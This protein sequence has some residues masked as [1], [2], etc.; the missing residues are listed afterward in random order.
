MKTDVLFEK[1]DNKLVITLDKDADYAAVKS[2]LSQVLELSSDTFSGVT[3][4][5]IVKGRRLLSDE[6]TEIKNMIAEK[7]ELEIKFEKPKQ[8]GLATIDNIFNKDI[9]ISLTKV[10]RGTIR[11]GQRL[12][13]EGSVLILGDVNGGAEV[14]AE[15]N[16]VVLGTLRGF[17][18]AGAKGNRSAFVAAE[19]ISPTQLRIA[20]VIMKHEIV[21]GD[22][23]LGYEIA[24][25]KMGEIVVEKWDI[26][27][28]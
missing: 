12:E 6:E 16:V 3:G 15:G 21:K 10:Y 2:K 22:M 9:T 27:K 4:T 11:S 7:T 19:S 5:I 1:K 28:P 24:S 17:A 26:L 8:M 18:H 14:I 20:D 13:F 25:I 23:E